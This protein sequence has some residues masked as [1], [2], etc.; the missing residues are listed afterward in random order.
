MRKGTRTIQF[1]FSVLLITYWY[2]ATC[3]AAPWRLVRPCSAF[4]TPATATF[5]SLPG[6]GTVCECRGVF[7]SLTE[8]SIKTSTGL[9]GSECNLVLPPAVYSCAFWE[10]AHLYYISAYNSLPKSHSRANVQ[11]RK[12]YIRRWSVKRERIWNYNTHI[13]SYMTNVWEVTFISIRLRRCNS[14]RSL[15]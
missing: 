5:I 12:F 9:A 4:I 11:D 13:V 3:A 6:L 14:C 2:V 15:R 7:P 8:F 1:K 10:E